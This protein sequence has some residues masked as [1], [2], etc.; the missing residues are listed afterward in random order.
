MDKHNIIP[1]WCGWGFVLA[2]SGVMGCAA[3]CGPRCRD[4]LG[5]LFGQALCSCARPE[6]GCVGPRPCFAP[7]AVG[8]FHGYEPTA[9]TGWPVGWQ[10]FPLHH[11]ELIDHGYEQEPSGHLPLPMAPPE[12]PSPPTPPV[13]PPP[14]LR[15]P[16]ATSGFLPRRSAFTGRAPVP[17]DFLRLPSPDQAGETDP[18]LVH[19][20]DE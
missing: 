13:S 9:W 7:G 14:A 3:P 5:S 19:V 1:K 11:G 10:P 6:S 15:M 17:S 8:P 18:P 20:A 2:A 4:D 12:H 16:E